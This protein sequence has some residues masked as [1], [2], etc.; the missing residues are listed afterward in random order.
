MSA[1]V[2]RSVRVSGLVMRNVIITCWVLKDIRITGWTVWM[3]GYQV[4]LYGMLGHQVR[5]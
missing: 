3:T 5:L 4:G 1:W 2:V